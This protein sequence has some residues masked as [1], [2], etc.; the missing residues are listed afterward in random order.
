MKNKKFPKGIHAH[1]LPHNAEEKRFADAWEKQNKEGNTL[2]YLL[3]CGDQT[4]HPPTPSHRDYQVAATIVQWLGSEVGEHFLKS[5]GYEQAKA[6][7]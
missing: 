3:H 4:G 5:L 2:A 1:R 6:L 7:R